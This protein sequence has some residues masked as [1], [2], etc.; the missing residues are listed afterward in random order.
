MAARDDHLNVVAILHRSDM[1]VR[2]KISY[3]LYTYF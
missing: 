3:G 1:V 2:S